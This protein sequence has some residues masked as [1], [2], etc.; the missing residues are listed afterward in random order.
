M[1]KKKDI[2]ILLFWS[3]ICDIFQHYGGDKRGGMR[4][5]AA[6]MGTINYHSDV[7]SLTVGG[8]IEN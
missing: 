2:L 6:N 8:N 7:S 1:L 5:T 4:Y 3:C